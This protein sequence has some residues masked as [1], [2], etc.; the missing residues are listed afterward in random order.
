LR[1]DGFL[2][3]VP[4]PKY[5]SNRTGLQPQ[6][7]T[8]EFTQR[9]TGVSFTPFD[10]NVV[11]CQPNLEFSASPQPDERIDEFLCYP[12]VTT[13]L[14]NRAV[15]GQALDVRW[16]EWCSR[17]QA[18]RDDLATFAQQFARPSLFD[19]HQNQSCNLE[20]FIRG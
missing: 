13:K 1:N 19:R 5:L 9:L 16:R 14:K 2:L 18:N 3:Q 17:F 8:L 7:L 11:R 12:F 20:W 10:L 6:N 4:T 15:P